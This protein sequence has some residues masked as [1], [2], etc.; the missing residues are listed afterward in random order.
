MISATGAASLHSKAVLL[1]RK[2]QINYGSK[3]NKGL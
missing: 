2:S 3:T 1:Q